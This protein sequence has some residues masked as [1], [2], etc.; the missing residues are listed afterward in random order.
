[1]GMHAS[2]FFFISVFICSELNCCLF[3]GLTALKWLAKKTVTECVEMGRAF[4]CRLP[5]S[6]ASVTRGSLV[7]GN[8]TYRLSV[9]M[10][11][12]WKYCLLLS[13]SFWCL[14]VESQTTKLIFKMHFFFFETVGAF[15]LHSISAAM[16][17]ASKGQ[18]SL[19]KVKVENYKSHISFKDQHFVM[20]SIPDRTQCYIC[21]HNIPSCRFRSNFSCYDRWRALVKSL[22]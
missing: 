2:V 3:Q 9:N 19:E 1:M 7:S 14:T 17:F 21:H 6:N 11:W 5:P 20:A 16:L 18:L 15:M 22:R 13:R 8:E 12:Q 10:V 4:K